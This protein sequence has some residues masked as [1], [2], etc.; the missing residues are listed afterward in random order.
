M[1]EETRSQMFCFICGFRKK[2][3]QIERG[4]KTC[5]REACIKESNKI[6]WKFK[7]RPRNER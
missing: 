2:R 3:I 6:T 4:N 1:R 5:G 7:N